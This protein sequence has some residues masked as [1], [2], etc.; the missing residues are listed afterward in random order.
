MSVIGCHN[1]SQLLHKDT[2]AHIMDL[3]YSFTLFPEI[4]T[5][6]KRKM[7]TLALCR[8]DLTYIITPKCQDVRPN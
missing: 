7:K 5:T 8:Y 1:M 4:I 6:F 2:S 3:H